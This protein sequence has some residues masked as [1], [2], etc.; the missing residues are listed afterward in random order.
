MAS[1]VFDLTFRALFI[2][3]GGLSCCTQLMNRK[4]LVASLLLASFSVQAET[5]YVAC[6]SAGIRM[7]QLNEETGELSS[8][9]E[10]LSL[11]GAGFLAL[12]PTKPVIYSTC[13]TE[14]EKGANGAIG[15]LEIL[16]NGTLDVLNKSLTK[17]GGA[18]HVSVDATGQVVFAASYGGGSVV[19]YQ[20]EE[21]GSLSE[22]VSFVKHEG[23][24]ILPKRQERPHAHYFAAGPSN[25]FAYAPDLGM[26]QVVI[27]RFDSES[28]E[29]TP[30]GAGVLEGGSGPRHMK[31]SKDGRF[32]YV[33][34]ELNLTVTVFA[35]DSGDG[36]LTEVETIS[37]VPEETEKEKMS[38]AEIV[39]HPNG[40]FV[41]TSQ[42]DLKTRGEGSPLGRN[43]LSVYRVTEKGTLQ[44]IQ[45]LSAGVR[46]PRNFNLNT[47]GAW[48]LAGGQSSQ[49]VQV[50]AIDEKTGKLAP[51][52]EPITC[53]GGP[54][55]FVFRKHED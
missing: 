31:F 32:A 10:A 14:G 12:H 44:R 52:G 47:S 7:A 41:Y 20:I 2:A 8:L 15:A 21:D 37:T 50:F 9:D 13:S 43:S 29:L 22:P 51:K 3:L 30:A 53:P 26:D 46:I 45:T 33:L 1:S 17:S 34:N 4:S 27:Y 39:V 36:S 25:V 49:D 11:P 24:S 40:K 5:V 42:R 19:S 18:C 38:C 48:L 35:Y 23:S 54:M 16:D 55:C 28:A 6:G